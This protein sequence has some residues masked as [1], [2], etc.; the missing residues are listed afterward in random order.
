MPNA[1]GSCWCSRVALLQQVLGS[2]AASHGFRLDELLG[3]ALPGMEGGDDLTMPPRLFRAFSSISLHL[4]LVYLLVFA[5]AK[6]FARLHARAA[7][8]DDSAR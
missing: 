7:A 4:L 2:Q 5:L 8:E 6:L 3:A 1:S